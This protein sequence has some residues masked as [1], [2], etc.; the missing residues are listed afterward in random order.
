M[1]ELVNFVLMA[2]GATKK[3]IPPDVDLDALEPEE[4]DELLSD[5]VTDMTSRERSKLYPLVQTKQIVRGS[6]Y[7]DQYIMFWEMLCDRL[8]N[9]EEEFMPTREHA[10]ML[11]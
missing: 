3:W 11:R 1:V 10:N 4:L 9:S 5:M 8:Q 2:A 6:T 7:R